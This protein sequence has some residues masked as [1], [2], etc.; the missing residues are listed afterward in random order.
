MKNKKLIRSTI[1]LAVCL[2]MTFAVTSV[3][4]CAHSDFRASLE[5]VGTSGSQWRC[6]AQAYCNSNGSA[7]KAVL[8]CSDGREYTSA[9]VEGRSGTVTHAY[10]QGVVAPVSTLRASYEYRS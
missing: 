2:V 8:T 10:T 1:A 6:H 5:L 9:W 3:A 4:N 7:I